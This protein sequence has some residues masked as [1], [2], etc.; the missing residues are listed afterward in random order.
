MKGQEHFYAEKR[1]II[2][3]NCQAKD[4]PQRK[5]VIV[6]TA[7]KDKSACESVK[8]THSVEINL[9]FGETS[10]LRTLVKNNYMN[11][12]VFD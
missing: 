9:K 10:Q 1:E 8:S 7:N 4:R 5:L 3:Q 11:D 12:F 2:Q 6:T